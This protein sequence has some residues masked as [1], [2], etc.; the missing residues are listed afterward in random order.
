[1]TVHE[2]FHVR[3]KEDTTKL[4]EKYKPT[5]VLHLAAVGKG[6]YAKPILITFNILRFPLNSGWPIQEHGS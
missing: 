6:S 3:V 4:F 1:M 5:H 2:R